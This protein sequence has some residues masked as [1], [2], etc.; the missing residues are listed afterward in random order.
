[1]N[2]STLATFTAGLVKRPVHIIRSGLLRL[3]RSTLGLAT[4]TD[5]AVHLLSP[6]VRA[7]FL[8]ALL[9]TT[10]WLIPGMALRGQYASVP[11]I[12]DPLSIDN[13]RVILGNS[14]FG[15][16]PVFWFAAAVPDAIR[17]FQERFKE[18]CLG[19]L[20]EL[21]VDRRLHVIASI[22]V[23]LALTVPL[24]LGVHDD[25]IKEWFEVGGLASWS[26]FVVALAGPVISLTHSF[27]YYFGFLRWFNYGV[28]RGLR[29]RPLDP[30]NCGGLSFVGQF[31]VRI[32]RFGLFVGFFP[33]W[34]L[35]LN[36]FWNRPGPGQTVNVWLVVWTGQWALVYFLANWY[37]LFAPILL[38]RKV[39][40]IERNRLLT[41][42]SDRFDEYVADGFLGRTVGEIREL[43]NNYNF[44][45]E[46]YPTWPFHIPRLKLFAGVS[47]LSGS[48]WILSVVVQLGQLGKLLGYI[49]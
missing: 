13:I 30:D 2:R 6:I 42:F 27:I 15:V 34:V 47:V 23:G 46:N 10:G 18:S 45:K 33:L 11:D 1:M 24:I 12:I 17:T 20:P 49:K 36:F 25:G 38:V 9:Q 43:T 32:S 44:V 48:A 14:L 26:V 39:M 35:G 37:M 3:F 8:T 28:Q 21:S 5:H 40:I 19:N 41:N 16:G 22:V 4:N 31:F 29:I 7:S